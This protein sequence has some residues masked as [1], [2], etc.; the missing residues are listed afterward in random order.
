MSDLVAFVGVVPE[1]SYILNAFPVMI[2]QDIIQGDDT[3]VAISSGRIVLETLQTLSV[4]PR[5]IPIHLGQPAVETR[6]VRRPR[7]LT[8]NLLDILMRPMKN[9]PNDGLCLT[10]GW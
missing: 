4:Q 2:N 6:L 1:V 3:V 5:D 7:K 8:A 9:L 10:G